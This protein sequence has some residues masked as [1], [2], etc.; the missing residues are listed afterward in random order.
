MLEF[1][2]SIVKIFPG[3]NLSQT[4][5]EMLI[6]MLISDWSPEAPKSCSWQIAELEFKSSYS[7]TQAFVFKFLYFLL[8]IEALLYLV[9][10]LLIM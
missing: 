8:R 6:I 7:P 10:F 1:A 3:L 2:L 9:L 4:K 5:K